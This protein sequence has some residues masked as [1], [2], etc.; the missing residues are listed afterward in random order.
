MNSAHGYMTEEEKLLIEQLQSTK[1]TPTAP[2]APPSQNAQN[3]REAY[4]QYQ[5]ELQN[6]HHAPAIGP[7]RNTRFMVPVAP[8]PISSRRFVDEDS[9]SIENI[10]FSAATDNK[11]NIK[12]S[13]DSGLGSSEIGDEQSSWKNGKSSKQMNSLTLVFS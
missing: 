7:P 13:S 9:A 6:G 2:H 12:L 5:N 4:L 10:N 3:M 1:I 8:S 11:K